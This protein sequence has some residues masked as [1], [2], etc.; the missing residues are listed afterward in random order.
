M[1]TV[2]IR[3][4]EDDHS[5]TGTPKG[6]VTGVVYLSYDP[7]RMDVLAS[8]PEP[9]R[10]SRLAEERLPRLACVRNLKRRHGV[11]ARELLR[12]LRP[13]EHLQLEVE[14]AREAGPPA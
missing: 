1:I 8:Y 4:Q 2:L 10:P 7:A 11:P 3:T 14:P 5:R 6:R 13:Q 9:G 12:A